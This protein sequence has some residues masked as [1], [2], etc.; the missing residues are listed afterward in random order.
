VDLA[1]ARRS[2]VALLVAIAAAIAA[3]L[4]YPLRRGNGYL[5]D[6][7]YLALG[8]HLDNPL[9]LLTQDSLGAFFFRPLGMFLWWWTVALFGDSAPAHLMFNVAVHALNGILV[10]ALLRQLRVSFAPAAAAAVLFIAHPAAFS[11]AAWLANRFD[12]FA[13]LFGLVALRAVDRVLELPSRARFAAALAATLAAMLCEEIGFA[14]PV[15][16]ALMAAWI[17]PNRHTANARQ[18]A[19]LVCALFACALVVVGVRP[20]VLR[21]ETSLLRDALL[22]TLWGGMWKL[23][24]GLPSFLVVLH[25]SVAA[26]SAWLAAFMAFAA[27]GLVP[28][29]RAHLREGELARVALIGLAIMLATALTEAPIA[30]VNPK[31]AY[32]L[33]HFELQAL[34]ACRLYYLPL[35]GFALFAGALLEAFVRLRPTPA[36]RYAK[37]LAVA[38]GIV[39]LAGMVATGRTIG[40][41][42]TALLESG[43]ARYVRAA[44]EAAAIRDAT[45]GCKIYFLGTP[46]SAFAFRL[47]ADVAVKHALPRGHRV[48]DC[49]VQSEHTPWFHLVP[50]RD[51]GLEKPLETLRI[52]GKPFAPLPVGNLM[53]QYLNVP[54]T[55][56][57]RD[58]PRASFYAWDGARF[59][60][61]TEEIRA[62]KREVRF[63]DIRPPS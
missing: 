46:V 51:G 50:A 45:P 29:V 54:D 31:F 57:V 62:R 34:I 48:V 8:R 52:A 53:Y 49:F 55:A 58:D 12:L 36:M 61:V 39:A 17:M 22:P 2:P 13:T 25:G 42:W 27:L 9:V 30:Y 28:A 18:R 32:Q 56:A 41:E 43:S 33:D 10:Y 16:A 7:A 44:V 24:A 23:T 37:L 60:D 4:A 59:A 21:T 40:R 11:T 6:F 19:V 63:F 26:V 47:Y 5:D 35:A 38:A 15:V 1:S 20:F 14:I 3:L